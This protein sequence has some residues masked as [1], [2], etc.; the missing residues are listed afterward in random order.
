MK[1]RLTNGI[2]GAMML[3]LLAPTSIKAQQETAYGT[4]RQP[5]TCPSRSEPSTGRLST[6]QA[7][8]YATCDAE[9]DQVVATPGIANFLEIL[10]LQVSPPRPVI[11]ADIVTYGKKIDRS[12][13]IYEIKGSAVLYACSRIAGMAPYAI[14]E[15][16]RNCQIWGSADSNSINSRGQC[17]TDFAGKWRCG[18]SILNMDS[19]KGPPPNRA[20]TL[21][22]SVIQINPDTNSKTYSKRAR[23]KRDNQDYQG[24][25]A[26]YNRAIQLNPNDAPSYAERG[27]IKLTRLK[28]R[29]GAMKDFQS[30]AQLYRQDGNTEGY[31]MVLKA[32]EESKKY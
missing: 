8:K 9:G 7:I 16:G 10:S 3:T 2:I 18:L 26:D 1:S 30:A 6:A 13:P 28:D 25:L 29:S 22:S 32:I 5:A 20:N 12:K 4:S 11:K 15:R 27:V 31:N 17:F 24:A 23:I 19:V 21:G 14:G